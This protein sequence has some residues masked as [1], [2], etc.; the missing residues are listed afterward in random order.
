LGIETR[1]YEVSL[2]LQPNVVDIKKRIDKETKGIL[3]VDYFGFPQNLEEIQE[4]CRKHRLYLIEDNAHGLLSYNDSRLLG[5][6]GDIGFSS[7]WKMLPVPNGAILFVNNEE[8]VASK[9]EMED[10]LMFQNQLPQMS[11][12]KIYTYILNSLL[13]NLELRYSFKAEFI[14]SIYQKLFPRE[15][16]DSRKMFQDSKVRIS[17]ISLRV[18]NN[19]DLENVVEK[20]RQ[21]YNF[22]LSELFGRGDVHFLFEELCT[23]ICPLCF[24]LIDKEAERFSKEMLARGIQALQWPPLPKEIKDNPEYPNANFLAKHLVLLPV[25]QSLNQDRLMKSVRR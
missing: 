2:N 8:L 5:T 22:W 23:G 21:N 1:F 9:R 17:D 20:R 10:F 25:H 15:E 18:I 6:F 13:C 11:K 14:S 24:A 3:I 16:F 19:I 12:R 4:I 7:I